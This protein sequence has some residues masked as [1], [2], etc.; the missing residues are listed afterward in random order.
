ML[1]GR[2]RGPL[3]RILAPIGKALQRVG[4]TAD[5]LTIVGLVF[6]AVTAVLIATGHFGWAVLGVVAT[7]LP[8]VLDGSVARHSGKDGPRGAFFDSVSD[9]VS[10][11]LLF[12][13]VAWYLAGT[14]HPR[15][16][17]LA[18]AV[19]GC[20]FVISYERAKAEGLGFEAK[21]GLMER[22]ERLLV[23]LLAL[24]FDV[25]VPAL[26]L[27]LA[28][29]VVTIVTRFAKVWRQAN[30]AP[31]RPAEPADRPDKPTVAARPTSNVVDLT[32]RPRTL[33]EWWQSR[34]PSGDSRR[35]R[36]RRSER[37]RVGRHNRP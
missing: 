4:V 2:A 1:D 11:L 23:L 3:E 17:V 30:A 9:R 26:W 33:A 27:M 28:L 8:D 14:A 36:E 10:D 12:G 35:S 32:G 20:A 5:A 19:A 6:S 37:R 24:A 7:G 21:G 15:N 25:L 16:A 13:G 29:S 34:R 31:N 22:A 18:M